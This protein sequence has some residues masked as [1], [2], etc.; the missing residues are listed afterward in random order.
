MMS[1]KRITANRT[2]YIFIAILV[3]IIA[4]L[5]LGGGP[6]IKGIMNQ[7]SSVNM[8]HWNWTQILISIGIGFILGLVV[9]RRR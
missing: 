4:F 3:I 6:W 2:V 5:L 8:A 1:T 9:G 7:G